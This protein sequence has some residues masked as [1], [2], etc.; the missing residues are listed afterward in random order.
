MMLHLLSNAGLK[1]EKRMNQTNKK[2][3][4]YTLIILF[5]SIASLTHISLLAL[6]YFDVPVSLS[7][8]TLLT[9][10]I[11]ICTRITGISLSNELITKKTALFWGVIAVLAI[12]F[13][14]DLYPHW[15]GG[16]DQGLYSSMADM[17][18]HEKNLNFI[19]PFRVQLSSQAQI[20]Y[21]SAPVSGL[22]LINAEQSLYTISFY[23][24]HP[25]WMAVAE[26]FLGQ[27]YH[28]LSL[29][30]FSLLAIV[31]GT[32]LTQEI[33]KNKTT[34]CLAA[35]FLAINP[36]MAFFSKFPVTEMLAF[37]FS[38]NGF[39]FLIRLM[40]SEHAWEKWI[41]GL[42]SL[43]SFNSLFYV[44]MQFFLFIPFFAILFFLVITNDSFKQY[45]RR[46]IIYLV[47]L[48]ISFLLSLYFYYHFQPQLF[49]QVIV[50]YIFKL[51]NIKTLIFTGSVCLVILLYNLTEKGHRQLNYY[52]EKVLVLSPWWLLLAFCV[53]IPTIIGLYSESAGY[54]WS[55]EVKHFGVIRY[56][57]LYRFMLMI[58]PLGLLILIASPFMRIKRSSLEN[59]LYLFI[60]LLWI[61]MLFQPCVPYLYYYGRYL[62]S[63]MLPYSLIL[64]AGIL[65]YGN[66][67]LRSVCIIIIL[68]FLFFSLAQL[69]WIESEDVS[70]YKKIQKIVSPKD[71]ILV[72]QLDDRQRLPFRLIEHYAIFSVTGQRGKSIQVPDET[73]HE[74]FA[75]AKKRG[76]RLILVRALPLPGDM[77]KPISKVN[78]ISKFLNNG[79]HVQRTFY[80]TE[81]LWR[82][83]WLPI[84]HGKKSFP[85][86]FYQI[87]DLKQAHFVY[88]VDS[89]NFTALNQM[90]YSQKDFISSCPKVIQLSDTSLNM[91]ISG[92]G[93]PEPQGRWTNGHQSSLKCLLPSTGKQIHT[94][95]FDV[96]TMMAFSKHPQHIEISINNQ[97]KKTFTLTSAN[98]TTMEV[99]I[100]AR[101]KDEMHVVISLPDAMHPEE[102]GLP[103]DPRQLGI[104]LNSIHIK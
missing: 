44:R 13:R 54:L 66:R 91:E 22:S 39:L 71:I 49:D 37:C 8:A 103:A 34:S 94:V 31:G 72:S 76:G 70:Y 89:N 27:E 16:Q 19:D 7:L 83:Y 57:A 48:L 26:F 98:S 67:T 9:V 58:S 52:S 4:L 93:N 50:Q 85:L 11:L 5:V 75:L 73:F 60:A 82:K 43:L 30:C 53:S 56:H 95:I 40:R 84:Y 96:S 42:V 77:L 17:F 28:T 20:I 101:V 68:Y 29:F 90:G 61:G 97:W 59:L 1:F 46:M 18:L 104:L 33:F 80:D 99:P 47:I 81:G 21:D 3:N 102:V 78:F 64:L 36:A 12:L 45:T 35:L 24:L 74:L 38:V 65:A 23:P 6:S 79:E 55:H 100:N 86:F 88:L 14:A 87:T 10:I 62:V 2:I 25:A 69:G 51:L 15:M 92:F 41:Y 63:E 32:L